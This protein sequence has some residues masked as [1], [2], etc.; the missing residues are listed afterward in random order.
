M[1]VTAA[2]Q[3]FEAPNQPDMMIYDTVRL[4]CV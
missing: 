4:V 3:F 2:K 1:S